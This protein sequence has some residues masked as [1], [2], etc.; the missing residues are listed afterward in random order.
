VKQTLQ[1]RVTR[2]LSDAVDPTV[3]VRARWR[4]IV[5]DGVGVEAESALG[6]MPDAT[7]DAIALDDA[8]D[9]ACGDADGTLRLYPILQSKIIDMGLEQ[10]LAIDE[11]VVPMI[12]AMTQ[13]GMLVDRE[14]LSVL[15][16]AFTQVLFDLEY[17]C[18]HAAGR[19]FSVTSPDQVSE[20][21]FDDLGLRGGRKCKKKERYSVD[22]KTLEALKGSHPVVALIQEHREI[23][24]LQ[25]TY[26]EVLPKLLSPDGR[27]RMELGMTV[28]PSGRLNCWGGVNLLGIPVRTELGRE[29]RRAF[30]APPGRKLGAVDLNQ[31]ELRALA[32][33]SGDERLLDAYATGKDL[34]A[35]TAAETIYHA[36]M[37]SITYEQ[38]QRGKTTNFA[39]ANQISALGLRD[40]FT[41]SGIDVDEVYCQQILDGWYGFY[42]KV[43]PF[44]DSVYE[45]GRRNGYIRDTL[46]GRILYTPGLR[47][48]I[49]K[50]RAHAERVATNW[51]I[52]TFAQATLKLGMALIW[53]WLQSDDTGYMPLLQVHD[54]AAWHTG[55]NWKELK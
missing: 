31:V 47:S 44:F 16:D 29:I 20:V 7:L 36:P 54:E 25:N 23:S 32:I 46:S 18:H 27:I 4:K 10:A 40:Q 14:H 2:L 11:A 34:H 22:D 38:R 1:Q 48:P 17:Q 52:Q 9:Y 41:L 3:D 15:N 53:E 13:N 43:P 6:P 39:I 45:E 51:K 49:D 12:V 21:L 37:P 26:V 42:D 5:E 35:L 8:V 19:T 30:I 28:V 50:V 55:L 33:L 24:K